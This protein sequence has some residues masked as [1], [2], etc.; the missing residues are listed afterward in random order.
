[1]LTRQIPP[2]LVLNH[3]QEPHVFVRVR[4]GKK[5]RRAERKKQARS[6]L[7]SESILVCTVASSY[8]SATHV[9]DA[10][11]G[12]EPRRATRV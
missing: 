9:F 12:N 2:I 11:Y 3:W 4:F 7:R 10:F 8:E 6:Y 1:M 5:N